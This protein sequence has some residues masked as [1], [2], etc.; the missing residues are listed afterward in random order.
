MNTSKISKGVITVLLLIG[1]VFMMLPMLYLI[2]YSLRPNSDMYQYPPTLFVSLRDITIEN[3]KYILSENI[4]IFIYF[5]NSIFVGVISMILVALMASSLAYVLSRYTFKG[6]K[7]I[8][9][10]IIATMIIPGLGLIIPQYQIAVKLNIINNLFGLIPVYTAWML[11]FST[12]MIKGFVDNLPRELDEAAYV[13]GASTMCVYF[14]II[15]PLMKPAIAA[16][17]IFNFL[18]SWEEYGWAQTVISSE[19]LRTIPIYIAGFF[20]RNNFT[21]FGYVFA[22]SFLSLIPILVIFISF[23]KY[24][25][26]GLTT[27][28]LKG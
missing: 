13:D 5:K 22:V 14:R 9:S 21:Q 7:F 2:S 8:F 16:V 3:Y 19:K 23:Q 20:G 12:F 26:T 6:K 28:G 4:N 18:T 25:I 24:F 17:S 1:A 15:F 11:P 10:L 27:G